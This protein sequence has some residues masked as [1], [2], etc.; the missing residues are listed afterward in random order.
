MQ[1]AM[2]NPHNNTANGVMYQQVGNK[3]PL[4]TINEKRQ[5]SRGGA[6]KRTQ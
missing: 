2:S 4:E 5:R 1:A 6:R 3:P